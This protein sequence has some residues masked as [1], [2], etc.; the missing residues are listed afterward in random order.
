M[1]GSAVHGGRRCG[2]QDCVKEKKISEVLEV[3]CWDES[4]SC[5]QWGNVGE[6]CKGRY[7]DALRVQSQERRLVSSTTR[8]IMK[9]N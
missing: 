9:D 1:V 8:G 4:A 7:R 2:W 3:M 5:Q 6:S